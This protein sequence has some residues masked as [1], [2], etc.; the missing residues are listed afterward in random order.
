MENATSSPITGSHPEYIASTYVHHLDFLGSSVDHLMETISFFSGMRTLNIS[1]IDL[2]ILA[3]VFPLCARV[4]P[5]LFALSVTVQRGRDQG[6]LPSTLLNGLGSHL[7]HLEFEKIMFNPSASEGPILLP[8]LTHLAV[9]ISNQEECRPMKDLHLLL[10]KFHASSQLY[11]LFL[12][13]DFNSEEDD[14]AYAGFLSDEHEKQLLSMTTPHVVLGLYQ[15]LTYTSTDRSPP[16]GLIVQ[17]VIDHFMN[18]PEN[19]YWFPHDTWDV[20]EKMIAQRKRGIQVSVDSILSCSS[21]SVCLTIHQLC[22]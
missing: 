10:E 14:L 11:L 5:W 1:Q 17:N 20:G 21:V 16:E 15:A 4:C 2:S 22:K 3:D 18:R 9:N 19:R 13:I 8:T 7:T 12:F 6:Y